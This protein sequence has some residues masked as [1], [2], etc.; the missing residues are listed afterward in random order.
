MN[1][2]YQLF[3][4]CQQNVAVHLSASDFNAVNIADCLQQIVTLINDD[5]IALESNAARFPC[6]LVQQ[7]IVR[8]NNQLQ[9]TFAHLRLQVKQ[10][11][12]WI[13]N[14]RKLCKNK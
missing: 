5:D 1:F 2:L 12:N 13:S 6:R 7:C 8:Q 3:T 10:L 9:P 11:L 4:K 14:L